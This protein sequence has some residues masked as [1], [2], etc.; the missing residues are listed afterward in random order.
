MQR[1]GGAIHRAKNRLLRGRIVFPFEQGYVHEG[2]F[3]DPDPIENR[4]YVHI[5]GDIS[6]P[7]QVHFDHIERILGHRGD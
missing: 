7:A 3:P 5:G 6:R 4:E 1:Q 2:P